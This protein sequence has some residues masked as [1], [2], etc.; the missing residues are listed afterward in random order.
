MKKEDPRIKRTRML[1][2]TAFLKL[3]E[4]KHT[5]KLRYKIF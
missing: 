3:L 5:K 2:Q 4:L 1:I